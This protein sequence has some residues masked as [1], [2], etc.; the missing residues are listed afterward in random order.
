[1]G[2]RHALDGWLMKQVEPPLSA[3]AM[4]VSETRVRVQF[5]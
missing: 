2:G 3:R 5:L 1:M 4:P